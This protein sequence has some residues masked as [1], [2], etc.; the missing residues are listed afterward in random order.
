LR[1][2]DLNEH[3]V[4]VVIIGWLWIAAEFAGAAAL[5]VIYR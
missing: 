5:I 4:A 1:R 2:I 3:W